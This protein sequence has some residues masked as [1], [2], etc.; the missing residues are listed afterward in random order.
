[1]SEPVHKFNLRLPK[2]L[3]LRARG[4]AAE[5]GMSLNAYI[6]GLLEAG[7]PPM[8]DC[9]HE[10]YRSRNARWCYRCGSPL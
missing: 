10:P 5:G 6:V 8:P 9:D 7:S 1:M 2:G 4:N 3:Y